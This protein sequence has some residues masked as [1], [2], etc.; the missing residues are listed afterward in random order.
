[1]NSDT[2]LREQPGPQVYANEVPGPTYYCNHCQRKGRP[3]AG[4]KSR[5]LPLWGIKQPAC[6]VCI[7][8][9]DKGRV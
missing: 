5:F 1:M 7:T 6:T 2:S 3:V 4:R 9:I 8:R